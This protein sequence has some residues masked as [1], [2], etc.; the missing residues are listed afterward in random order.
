MIIFIPFTKDLDRGAFSCGKPELDLWL[1]TSAGQQE[2]SNSARTILAVD[3]REACIAA[4][5]SLVTHRVEVDELTESVARPGRR[6]PMS[7]MLLAR[8]AVDLKYQG[9][10]F[11]KMVLFEALSRLSEAA[12]SIGFELVIVHALDEDAAAF[13]LKFG[14]QRLADHS[15]TLFMTAKNLRATFESESH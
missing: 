3:E 11:G 15:L 14:F 9:N 8:L 1:R 12:Q 2:R 13:Y 10:G 4:Y 5:F 7:A 6:Y